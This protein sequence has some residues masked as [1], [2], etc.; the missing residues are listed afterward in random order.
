MSHKAPGDTPRTPDARESS[1][2][3]I[4]LLSRVLLAF[5]LEFERE[6]DL[7]I[8]ISANVIRLLNEK[9]LRLQDLPRLSGV[10]NEAIAMS[11]GFL[12]KR[13]Y[14]VVGPNPTGG[15][16]K[17]VRLTPKGI[18]AQDAYL[19]LLA[20]IEGRWHMRFSSDTIRSLRDALE[21]LVGEPLL[22]GLESYPDGW[23][24]SVPKPETLPHYPMV[25]HRGGYPDG[26]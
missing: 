24:A 14:V 18:E 26:S 23:R 1:D 13:R 7:S 15:R 5:A 20:A 2:A 21:R 19:R 4:A 17:L 6:S 16:A 8:A 25:L 22:R 3:L 11:V 12:E 10:S 9:G